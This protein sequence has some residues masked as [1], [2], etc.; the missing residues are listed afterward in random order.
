MSEIQKDFNI[1]GS[2]EHSGLASCSITQTT[3]LSLHERKS[4]TLARALT[5]RLHNTVKY[6]EEFHTVFT[7]HSHTF[8]ND[9]IV[10]DAFLC[11]VF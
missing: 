8:L 2:D 1:T 10:A 9:I 6:R 3:A 4:V 11:Y 7:I 5:Q